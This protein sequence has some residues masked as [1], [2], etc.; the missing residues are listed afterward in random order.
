[1]R[2]IVVLAI[3]AGVAL[4]KYFD[5][6]ANAKASSCKGTLGGVR[7]VKQASLEDMA[8][9]TRVGTRHLE[10]LEEERLADLP[11]PV[12]VRGFIRAYCG[13]LRESPHTA[14]DLYQTLAGVQA[15]AA[16]TR[17]WQQSQYRRTR[18]TAGASKKNSSARSAARNRCAERR[19]SMR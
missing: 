2:R 19:S 17:K 12:F 8:R 3:L 15:A 18:P 16:A 4:P 7:A 10:A 14:L 11:S 13:F 6:S 9:S 5:Y 1:M